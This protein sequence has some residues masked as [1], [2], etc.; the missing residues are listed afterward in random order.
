MFYLV[1]TEHLQFNCYRKKIVKFNHRNEI[2]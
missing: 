2:L 1:S